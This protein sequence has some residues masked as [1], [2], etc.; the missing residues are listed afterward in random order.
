M[1]LVL[2]AILDMGVPVPVIRLRPQVPNI[3]AAAQF[4]RNQVIHF[5]LTRCMAGDAIFGEDFFLLGFRDM[6]NRF[7]VS[8]L[9]H[10]IGGGVRK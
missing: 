2:K 5:V 10:Y 3:V 6:A 7:R 1:E 9:G 8:R 4:Q